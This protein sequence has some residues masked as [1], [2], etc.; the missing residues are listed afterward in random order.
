LGFDGPQHPPYHGW[1]R[2]S[3]T[4]F[5][6]RTIE[7]TESGKHLYELIYQ[8]FYHVEQSLIAMEESKQE[9]TGTVRIAIPS[10]LMLSDIFKSIVIEYSIEFPNVRIEIENHHESIDLKRQGFDL[11]VLPDAVGVTDDSYV[12]FSLLHYGSN[13]VA[14]PGYLESHPPCETVNDL[15]SH[16]IFT[17][18]YNADLLS[19]DIPVR[20]KTDDLNLMHE[21]ALK[22]QGIA[23]LP[24]THSKKSLDSGELVKVLPSYKF[25]RLSLTLIY[26]SAKALSKKTRA[27]IDLFKNKLN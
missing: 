18:R 15:R 2:H 14:S 8:Q 10:A 22:G 11:Q 25:P 17:N 3:E 27:F 12:Q 24:Q 1:Q 21:L 26:P 6:G 5:Q 16:R 7:L 13:L 20:L 19:E 9:F 23:F 4:L